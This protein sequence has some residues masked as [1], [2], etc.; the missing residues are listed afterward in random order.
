MRLRTHALQLFAAT[1]LMTLWLAVTPFTA[2]AAQNDTATVLTVRGITAKD[3]T[4]TAADI[5][6]LPRQTLTV[7]EKSGEDVTYEGPTLADVMRRAGL[8]FESNKHGRSLT[9]YLLAEAA[10]KYRIVYALPEFD[11]AF[12]DRIILVAT[13]KDGK[14][15]AES[16]GPLRI[17]V[18][19]DKRP[20]R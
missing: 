18:P 2:R 9:R 11:P 3:V 17:I 20:A 10:D 8:D 4:L 12:T 14:P 5:E 15:I 16:E 19:D 7:K 13:R 1:A 6:K